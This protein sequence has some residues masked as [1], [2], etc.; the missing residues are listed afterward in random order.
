M[1]QKHAAA[2]ARQS[3]AGR[4]ARRPAPLRAC[5]RPL[6]ASVCARLHQR[7]VDYHQPLSTLQDPS[8]ITEGICRRGN[9]T[10]PALQIVGACLAG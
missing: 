1:L 6:L 4:A 5:P 7:S 2:Q 8:Y 9:H 3:P 10:G